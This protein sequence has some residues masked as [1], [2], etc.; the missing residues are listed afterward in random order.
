MAHRTHRSRQERGVVII[1]LALF[2]LLMICF[3]AVGVDLAKL[4]GTR[5]Q[6]QNAADAA[7]LAGASSV[8]PTTGVIDPSTALSRV[9]QTAA[10][11]K[12][13][14][15]APQPV[16]VEAG[17]VTFPSSDRV[18][19]TVRREGANSIVTYFANALGIASLQ[20]KASA[21]AKVDTAKTVSCG[22]VPLAAAPPS[23]TDF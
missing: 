10:L 12:A 13:F 23:G 11:N 4:M 16:V 15:D 7:A 9:Q 20:M 17:D 2:M 1:W 19:V 22:I 18:R 14:I 5:T 6:L 8:S 21:T 3:I